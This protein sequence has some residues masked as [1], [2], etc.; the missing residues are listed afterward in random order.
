VT[1]AVEAAPSEPTLFGHPRGL[2]YLAFT[3]TWERFSFLGMKAL[4]VLYMVSQLLKPGHVENIAGFLP[5]R[6]A[7][8][9]AM[10]A[11]SN[12]ALA[13]EIFGLYGSAVYL[14]PILGGFLADRLLGRRRTVILGAL[15]MAGGHFLMAF[16][17]PFLLALICMVLGAGCFK[18]NIASQVGALYRPD[19]QR[20]AD[21][22]QIFYVGI[23]VGAICAPLVCG[24]LGERMGWHY[25]FGAAGVGMLVGLAIY[26]AGRKHLPGD[27][28]RQPRARRVRA[29][30]SRRE[31]AVITLLIGLLPV[32]AMGLVG[33]QQVG[34][35]YLVWARA[36]ADLTVLGYAVPVTW[37]LT[38][39]AVATVSCLA[40]SVAFWRAWARRLP[41]PDELSKIILGFC[42]MGLGL[43]ALAAGAAQGA[44]L[45][46][47]VAIGWLL[48]FATLNELG[49][50]NVLPVALALYARAA[51]PAF[52]S[53]IIGLYYLQLVGA[54][55]IVGWLGGLL[56]RMPA[57][58]FWGLHA[59]L[60]GATVVVLLAVKAVGGGLLAAAPPQPA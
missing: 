4:L 47:P 25:G 37:L 12:Q 13:S 40:G 28:V 2:A 24:T 3:E 54:N 21:A 14:T 38:F 18:G 36:N 60:V 43:L 23:N 44:A 53:T 11:L 16:E 45:G 10:G 1:A 58:A 33:N 41:E 6:G 59:G 57:T 5:F 49:F 55:L 19:D 17:Q 26:L 20:R 48:G 39:E 52:G 9:G 22:F 42:L 8:E 51:P 15:L 29:A 30:M 56:H 46:R 27:P 7:I 31:V 32:F 50:A 34:N 35:A